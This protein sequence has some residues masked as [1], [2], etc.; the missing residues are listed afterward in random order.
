MC[1]AGFNNLVTPCGAIQMR[2]APDAIGERRA[3]PDRIRR[4]A[5]MTVAI[6]TQGPTP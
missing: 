2:F 3:R 4:M 6:A 1:R 5:F